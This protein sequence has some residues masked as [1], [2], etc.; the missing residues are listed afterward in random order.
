MSRTMSGALGVTALAGLA[1]AVLAG[2]AQADFNSVTVVGL[3]SGT[4]C[5]VATGCTIQAQVE[6]ASVLTP[7]EFLVDG[8]S[9][10]TA[11]PALTGINWTAS[12][13]WHPTDAR[14]YTITARQ[15]GSSVSVF[16]NVPAAGSTSCSLF[17][18]G[19]SNSGSGAISGSGTTGSF[20]TGSA[21]SGSGGSGSGG[22]G[23][24]C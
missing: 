24:G 19:S 1:A 23:S 13:A 20:G 6:G 10:G 5:S 11:T 21:N 22:S 12:L 3:Q 17:P 7:V 9:L 18:T 15:G 8:T 4:S 16:T 2:P 14:T